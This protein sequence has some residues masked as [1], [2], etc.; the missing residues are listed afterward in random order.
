MTI[1]ELL[2]LT[3]DKDGSDL[4][5]AVGLPPMIRIYGELTRLGDFPILQKDQLKEI[6][7]S[8][9][10][11]EQRG[12]FEKDMELDL[13]YAT[14]ALGRF[15]VNVNYEKKGISTIIRVISSRIPTPEELGLPECVTQLT[16]LKN[17]LILVT[18]PTGSGK[19]T[20]LA[21]II[22][23]INQERPVHILTV[24]DPI[25]FV[26][27]DKKAIVR[28]REVGA[29]TQSF[30][31]AL[32]HAMR[33]DPN[34]VLIGEMRDL[35]TIAATL[36]MAETGHLALATLH[37]CD[38][39]QTVDRMIDVFPPHQQQ[40]IRLMVSAALRAIVCQQ[41]IPRKGGV[42]RVASREILLCDNAISNLIREGK[43]PLIYQTI[44]TGKGVGMSTMEADI[45][46]LYMQGQITADSALKACNRPDVLRAMCPE[47]T[48]DI[49]SSTSTAAMDSKMQQEGG[50]IF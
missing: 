32:R 3:I 25:E 12:V 7:Y 34:V 46:R 17:G 2:K 39:S 22:N 42:G 30:T 15:R 36:T 16:R 43:T 47:I 21:S 48:K 9:L 5:L 24:E 8:M 13:C 38:A 23:K 44:Q 35:E 26:Y 29:H 19:S 27:T 28:Q 10:T 6:V 49:A 37:T 4:H 1:D 33:Q 45:K 31:H 40:Q 50:L 20:T 18:G 41:L 14:E 11:P